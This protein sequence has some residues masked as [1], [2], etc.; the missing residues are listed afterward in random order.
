MVDLSH[1]TGIVQKVNHDKGFE[2]V[3]RTSGNVKRFCHG[4]RFLKLFQLDHFNFVSMNE[5]N[6]GR[7]DCMV[8]RR[9]SEECGNLTHFQTGVTDRGSEKQMLGTLSNFQQN[10]WEPA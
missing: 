6:T 10:A 5:Q 1:S 9:L 8:L 7:M 2:G 4:T 3:A